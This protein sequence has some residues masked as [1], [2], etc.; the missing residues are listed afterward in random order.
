M[1]VSL[2]N[3]TFVKVNPQTTATQCTVAWRIFY[4][5]EPLSSSLQNE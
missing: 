2:S 4:K 1:E 5:E 3:C